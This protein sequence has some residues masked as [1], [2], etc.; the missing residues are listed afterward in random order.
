VPAPHPAILPAPVRCTVH[1][2]RGLN[3]FLAD[4]Y[5]G[6]RLLSE[7]LDEGGFEPAE[8][9]WL[10][11][12]RR[13]YLP[14]LVQ[15]W[16]GEWQTHLEPWEITAL[17]RAYGLDGKAPAGYE[18]WSEMTVDALGKVQGRLRRARLERVALVVAGEIMAET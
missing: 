3:R 10:R 6:P 13:R 7:I 15:G 17:V 9:A 8:V 5:G 18:V 4:L 14:R 16:I 11:D 12:R 2:R 1:L